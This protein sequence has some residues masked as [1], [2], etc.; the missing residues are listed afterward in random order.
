MRD[1]I[2]SRVIHVLSLVS[3]NLVLFLSDSLPSG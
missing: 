1:L 3:W 2:A